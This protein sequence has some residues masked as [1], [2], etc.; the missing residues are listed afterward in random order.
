LTA[1]ADL[2]GEG[3]II[4][5]FTNP[6]F[7][8]GGVVLELE[9]T[10]TFLRVARKTGGGVAFEFE[11][12]LGAFFLR[13]ADVGGGGLGAFFLR[14]TDFLGGLGSVFDSLFVKIFTLEPLTP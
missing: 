7:G 1:F 8:L 12:G 5:F 9:L 14:E 6:F 3:G 10:T 2:G 13:E 4:D 11:E